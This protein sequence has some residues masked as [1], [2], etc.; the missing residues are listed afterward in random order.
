MIY[1]I[2]FASVTVIKLNLVLHIY[3]TIGFF[4][5]KRITFMHSIRQIKHDTLERNEYIITWIFFFGDDCFKIKMNTLK[6][7]S[8]IKYLISTE[9]FYDPSYLTLN[10]NSP[11]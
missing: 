1:S 6:L 10:K 5:H 8:N 9:R 4:A 11:L 2:H 7:N 3:A